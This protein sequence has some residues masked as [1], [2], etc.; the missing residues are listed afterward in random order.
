VIHRVCIIECG[1]CVL[2]SI[3]SSPHHLVRQAPCS[4]PSRLLTVL[5]NL[6]GCVLQSIR[7][8]GSEKLHTGVYCKVYPQAASIQ[9]YRTTYPCVTACRTPMRRMAHIMHY[10]PS[11]RIGS[12]PVDPRIKLISSIH[13]GPPS[14]THLLEICKCQLPARWAS[15][16]PLSLAS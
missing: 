10:L 12:R 9:F 8:A 2:Q 4:S 6:T 7:Q 5:P 11:L 1:W 13:R 15:R 3:P 16:Y 14:W